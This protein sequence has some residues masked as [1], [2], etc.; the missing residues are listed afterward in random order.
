MAGDSYEVGDVD[1][2]AI[3]VQRHRTPGDGQPVWGPCPPRPVTWPV[4]VGVVPP[5]MDGARMRQGRSSGLSIRIWT[6][7]SR[8]GR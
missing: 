5:Y 8:G 1:K 6:F 3:V 2:D 4:W 7:K